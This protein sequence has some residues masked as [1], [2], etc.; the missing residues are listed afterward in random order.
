MSQCFSG[1][2]CGHRYVNA[3]Y[4]NEVSHNQFPECMSFGLCGWLMCTCLMNGTW[5]GL[6]RPSHKAPFWY[7]EKC[8]KCENC[9]IGAHMFLSFICDQPL[10]EPTKSAKSSTKNS[11]AGGGKDAGT[12]NSEEVKMTMWLLLLMFGFSLELAPVVAGI[13]LFGAQKAKQFNCS[14]F[15]KAALIM[16]GNM[17][18]NNYCSRCWKLTS[19]F[20][21]FIYVV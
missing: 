10:Q 8:T 18:S 9:L 7:A 5:F 2:N 19:L 6:C 3:R 17:W 12:E 16:H 20:F 11:N 13:R 1:H 4:Q 14:A 15:C 21:I